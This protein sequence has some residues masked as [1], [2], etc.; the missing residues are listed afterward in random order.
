MYDTPAH[1]D[2]MLGAWNIGAVPINVN[3]RYVDD[4]LRYLFA[5]ADLKLVVSEPDLVERA[6]DAADGIDALRQR[7]RAGD[8]WER[9]MASSSP[10]RPASS[11]FAMGCRRSR[12]SR[13]R[14]CLL[15]LMHGGRPVV[16]DGRPAAGRRRGADPRRGFRSGLRAARD[17]GGVVIQDQIVRSPSGK[18]DYRWAAETAR[19]VLEAG[20]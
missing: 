15:P 3:F 9:R 6:R 11:T 2:L 1:V 4:E 19:R 7:A 17:A 10:A 13:L 16:A 12:I 20:G 8:A 14:C 18:P 5:D